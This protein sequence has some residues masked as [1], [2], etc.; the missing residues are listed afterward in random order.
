MKSVMIALDFAND[1]E[2]KSVMQLLDVAKRAHTI[3]IT[4]RKDAKEKTYEGEFLRRM[5]VV[6]PL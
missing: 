2:E 3:T 4:V 5:V 6:P 1:V